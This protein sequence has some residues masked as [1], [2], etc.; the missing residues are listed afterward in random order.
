M[1]ICI[2]NLTAVYNP[3]VIAYHYFLKQEI[4]QASV[5]LNPLPNSKTAPNPILS[6]FPVPITPSP[7]NIIVPWFN[8]S[9][10]TDIFCGAPLAE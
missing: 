10:C 5:I 7:L 3:A 2:H 9:D 6:L 1:E 4:L 8:I